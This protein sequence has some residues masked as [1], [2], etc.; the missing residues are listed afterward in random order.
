M[1]LHI[2]NENKQHCYMVKYWP[3][4]GMV[5]VKATKNKRKSDEITEG[6]Q[7]QEEQPPGWGKGGDK[8]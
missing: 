6:P 1:I 4:K 8:G 2:R 5:M 7:K 3:N